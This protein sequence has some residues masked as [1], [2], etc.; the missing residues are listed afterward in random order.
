MT[1]LIVLSRNFAKAVE[2]S[3]ACKKGKEGET[4]FSAGGRKYDC[5]I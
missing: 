1:K 2:K 3:D 4:S 5:N